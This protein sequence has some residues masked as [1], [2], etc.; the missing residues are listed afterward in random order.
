MAAVTQTTARAVLDT[1]VL[2]PSG[3]CRDLQNAAQEGMFI[4]LWSP[5]IIA[6]LNRVL[7]WKWLERT[8]QP[9]STRTDAISYGLSGANW[10]RCTAAAAAMMEILVSTFEVVA[11][12]PPYPEAWEGL[13]DPWDVPIWA[14]AVDGGAHFVVSDNKRDYPSRQEDGR[15][16]HRGVEYLSGQD[17]LSRL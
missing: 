4:A 1:N 7:T 3:L 2:V 14:A 5:W 12:R 6:E 9:A 15:H 10:S 13:T 8:A 17:F 11:P 16:I